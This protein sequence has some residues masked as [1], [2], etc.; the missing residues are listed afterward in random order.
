MHEHV[1]I[2]KT[3]FDIKKKNQNNED[4][5]TKNNLLIIFEASQEEKSCF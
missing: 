1:D 3:Y 2:F 5:P 4:I